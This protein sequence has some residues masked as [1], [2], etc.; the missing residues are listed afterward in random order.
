MKDVLGRELKL[1]DFVLTKGH[2]STSANTVGRIVRFTKPRTGRVAAEVEIVNYY[3]GKMLD[4][5]TWEEYSDLFPLRAFSCYSNIFSQ[6][7]SIQFIKMTR[8]SCHII[9][10]NDVLTKE[11]KETYLGRQDFYLQ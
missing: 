5:V 3:V 7:H 4:D 6:H 9:L 2:G 1:G 8:Y 11:Q 10:A